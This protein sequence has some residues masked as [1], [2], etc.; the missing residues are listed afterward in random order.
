VRRFLN[1]SFCK[2]SRAVTIFEALS[3]E[4]PYF[5]E[6][7]WPLRIWAEKI[8]LLVFSYGGATFVCWWQLGHIVL[9]KGA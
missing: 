2:F 5:M 6:N 3:C 1:I 8:I 7:V 9:V 4:L